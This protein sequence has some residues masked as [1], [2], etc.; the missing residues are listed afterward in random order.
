MEF[1]DN[2]HVE[3]SF[4]LHS[5]S[6]LSRVNAFCTIIV[7]H[8]VVIYSTSYLCGFTIIVVYG[9]LSRLFCTEIGSLLNVN[10]TTHNYPINL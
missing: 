4:C 3:A 1:D 8:P 5:V 6:I 10:S 2:R 9:A 7:T